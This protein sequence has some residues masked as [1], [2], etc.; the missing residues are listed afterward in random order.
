MFVCMNTYNRVAM[1][2]V[3][4]DT[5]VMDTV[6]METVVMD[7]V[8]TDKIVIDTVAIDNLKYIIRISLRSP[9]NHITG[10]YYTPTTPLLH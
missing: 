2:T 1:D 6:V 8:A 7:M 9:N 3:V 5:V 10:N 4:M